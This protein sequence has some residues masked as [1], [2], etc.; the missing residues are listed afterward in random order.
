MLH[1][2]AAIDCSEI[3]IVSWVGVQEL[4]E[5]RGDGLFSRGYGTNVPASTTEHKLI[6]S[7]T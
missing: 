6:N 5:L 3:G 2:V 7:C 1:E 4:R